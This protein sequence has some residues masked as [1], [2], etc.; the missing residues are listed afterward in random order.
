MQPIMFSKVAP[1]K[2][3]NDNKKRLFI[4]SFYLVWGIGFVGINVAMKMHHSADE[5][6]MQVIDK[7]DASNLF[8]LFS[9][10]R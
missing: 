6:V 8:V 1:I 9:T 5:P 10:K 4:Y 2:K 7:E 3:K